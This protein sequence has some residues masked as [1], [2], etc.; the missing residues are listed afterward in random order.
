MLPSCLEERLARV[1]GVAG[2]VEGAVDSG[3]AALQAGFAGELDGD[4]A[5]DHGRDSNQR[6]DDRRHRCRNPEMFN[7]L[8]VTVRARGR[9][10]SD[11]AWEQ[12]EEL[13]PGSE[14]G[15]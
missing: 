9:G 13:G 15:R 5:Q 8:P 3:A 10:G 1:V 14:Y 12:R 4:P 2:G 11:L 7:F 6:A